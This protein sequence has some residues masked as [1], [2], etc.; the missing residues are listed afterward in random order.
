MVFLA[1][2]WM[3]DFDTLSRERVNFSHILRAPFA[4]NIFLSSCECFCRPDWWRFSLFK[5][6]ADFYQ[7]SQTKIK[8]NCELTRRNFTSKNLVVT[9]TTFP[10]DLV[11]VRRADYEFAALCDLS[12]TRRMRTA[13]TMKI[14]YSQSDLKLS[15][16]QHSTKNS[17]TVFG[18]LFLCSS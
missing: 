4:F 14:S 10:G 13:R 3:S 17:K 7:S 9:S 8:Q 1:Y 12:R 15:I 5:P 18:F 16:N 6:V 11:V 2:A